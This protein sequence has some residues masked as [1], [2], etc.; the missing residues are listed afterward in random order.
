MTK[1]LALLLS[2]QACLTSR[3]LFALL[4]VKL[5]E[6]VSFRDPHKM[7]LLM[8]SIREQT[9]IKVV[10]LVFYF[11]LVLSVKSKLALFKGCLI[12]KRVLEFQTNLQFLRYKKY[13][14]H[15][16]FVCMC[17]T[18]LN[19]FVVFQNISN[20]GSNKPKY[21][22]GLNKFLGLALLLQGYHTYELKVCVNV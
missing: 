22:L 16:V 3:Y 4:S 12:S 11:H 5:T 15:Q 21:S 17:K 19:C 7:L 2:K 9:R 8:V 14:K 13:K 18:Y 10:K 1:H 20:L 6:Q